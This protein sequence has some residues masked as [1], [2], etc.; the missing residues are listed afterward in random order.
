MKVLTEE[1]A[2]VRQ[3]DGGALFIPNLIETTSLTSRRNYSSRVI[4]FFFFFLAFSQHLL[5]FFK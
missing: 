1:Q 2:Y 3:A 5:I 4:V